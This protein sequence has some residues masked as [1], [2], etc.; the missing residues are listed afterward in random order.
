[1][2]KAGV[3]VCVQVDV[4]PE[5]AFEIFTSE[6]GSWWRPLMKNRFRPS[7]N[8][9]MRFEPG[10]GG[11]LVEDA[12]GDLYEVGRV[13]VWEPGRRLLFDWRLPNYQPN[14]ITEVE[15]Q[16]QAKGSGT[17]V[18][19][20][21]RGFQDL[22]KDHPARHG[23]T[24]DA[25]YARMLG[26]WWDGILGDV[27]AWV[28]SKQPQGGMEM[29][30]HIRPGHLPVTPYLA[31]SDARGLLEFLEKAFGAEV[32]NQIE[33]DGKIAHA[34]V[35]LNG[36]VL[37]CGDA[38]APFSPMPAT[39]SVYVP[40]CDA[41]FQRCIAAGGKVIYEPSTHDYGDRSGGVEDPTG[42]KWWVTT[43]VGS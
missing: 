25:A 27:Q 4:A 1:M 30:K 16:F 26:M 33:A 15:V 21:H 43:H 34:E 36:Q 20:E 17:L 29:H 14:E 19:L 24:D 22:P 39:F 9:R 37:M 8:G 3:A 40:D 28:G 38:R 18:T 11:R 10:E 35:R 2:K 5:A 12:D 32:L 23:I 42:N 13:R 31:S 6:I 7:K 41:V